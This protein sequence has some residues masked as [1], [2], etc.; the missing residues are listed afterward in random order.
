MSGLDEVQYA[1]PSGDRPCKRMCLQ[2]TGAKDVRF[3]ELYG[4]LHPVSDFPLSV[5]IWCGVQRVPLRGVCSVPVL[6]E[7]VIHGLR[8]PNVVVD[9]GLAGL[10]PLPPHH[11]H[12]GQPQPRGRRLDFH[13]PAPFFQGYMPVPCPAGSG[14]SQQGHFGGL[15]SSLAAPILAVS[16][17]GG[18]L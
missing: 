12:P 6:G 9:A 8:G 1:L 5:T 3:S 18:C 15:S 7:V 2:V 4:A 13:P 10:P 14:S 17:A 11:R 16:L